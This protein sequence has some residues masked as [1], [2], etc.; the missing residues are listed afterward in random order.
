M[1]LGDQLAGAVVGDLVEMAVA[2]ELHE[3]RQSSQEVGVAAADRHAFG[4]QRV[5][6]DLP[7]PVHV[8]EHQLVGDEHVVEVDGVEHRVARQ[9]TQRLYLHA[10]AFHV[11]QEIGDAVVLRRVRVGPG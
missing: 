9:F 8:T 6:A 10:L 1:T 7:A 5:A 11:Q 2:D 4:R 3:L